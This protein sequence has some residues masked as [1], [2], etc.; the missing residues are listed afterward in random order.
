MAGLG[1]LPASARVAVTSAAWLDS[2]C[3][4]ASV[5]EPT[6][7][8]ASSGASG[9]GGAWRGAAAG[10]LA[11][12][13]GATSP[14]KST[15]LPQQPRLTLD[16]TYEQARPFSCKYTIFHTARPDGQDALQY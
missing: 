10:S 9:T 6:R 3:H 2:E 8:Q 14:N 7:E 12:C 16:G 15:H 1:C 13:L 11:R 5:A 4:A